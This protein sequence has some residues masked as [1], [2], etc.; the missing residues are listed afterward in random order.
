MQMVDNIL[1]SALLPWLHTSNMFD[2]A[3]CIRVF[4]ASILLRISLGSFLSLMNI[5]EKHLASF[6]AFSQ[7]TIS[8]WLSSEKN[9]HFEG[10]LLFSLNCCLKRCA[11]LRSTPKP[12]HT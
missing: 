3:G 8:L 12:S 5:V 11:T 9:S 10:T 7:P 1:A 2:C 4:V 6:S